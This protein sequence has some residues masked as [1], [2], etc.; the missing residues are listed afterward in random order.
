MNNKIKFKIYS[1]DGKSF[2][3]EIDAIYLDVPNHGIIGLLKGHTPYCAMLHI[4]T[5]YTINN[6]VKTYFAISGGTI[7]FKNNEAILLAQTYEKEDEL[8]KARIEKVRDEAINLLSK[9]D[10]NDQVAYDNA[11]FTLK[12]AI[13]RLKIL[14]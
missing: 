11:S 3:E 12:K 14:K 10:K 1:I 9:I 8:D 6:G 5:F 7:N 13:N 2:E 4:S